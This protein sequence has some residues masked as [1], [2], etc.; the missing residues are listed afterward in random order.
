MV[1]VSE[2][3]RKLADSGRTVLVS[4]HDPELIELCCDDV[5]CIKNGKAV[6]LEKSQFKHS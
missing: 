2:L 3:L 5:L 4:T 1:K 6:K